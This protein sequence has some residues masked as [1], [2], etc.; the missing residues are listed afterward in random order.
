LERKDSSVVV[1]VRVLDQSY[2]TCKSTIS[3]FLILRDSFLTY[4]GTIALPASEE[5][6]CWCL[7]CLSLSREA[8]R[9]VE[10]M[11]AAVV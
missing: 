2:P 5:V 4:I 7:I 10:G 11:V 3:A 6:E 8:S 9:F 1:E